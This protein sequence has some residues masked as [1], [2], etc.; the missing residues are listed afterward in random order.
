MTSAPIKFF[1]SPAD[2]KLP[3]IPES[4]VHN[5]NALYASLNQPG[6]S[7]GEQLKQVYTYLDE[8]RPYVN[9]FVSCSKGCSHCCSI[10]V[11]L[12]TL[13]AEYIQV[14]AGVPLDA[15]EG[16]TTG[17]RTPCPFL[18]DA[19]AC[20]IY[21]H[22]P[23]VCRI[24]HA[25]GDPKNCLPG[26]SQIQYGAPPKY[27]NDIFANLVRWVHHVTAHANGTCKDIRNFFPYPRAQVQSF[28]SQ[29]TR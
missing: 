2:V 7:L 4:L 29:R 15:R 23:V 6:R 28:L 12:T 24:Y 17:H 3:P 20:G 16:L 18:T 1:K 8:F 27:G 11:Q 14:Y 10:D 26:R 19:G 22:R 13:E 5:A 25:L 9:S 21:E